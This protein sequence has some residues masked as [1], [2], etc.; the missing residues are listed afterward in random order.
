MLAWKATAY[1]EDVLLDQD[2][3]RMQHYCPL[4]PQVADAVRPFLDG[5]QDDGPMFNQHSFERWLKQQKLQVLHCDAHLVP[6]DLRK[7]CEQDSDNRGS[8]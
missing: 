2:K 6:G 5:G 1:R 7:F 8:L 3:I 4:H